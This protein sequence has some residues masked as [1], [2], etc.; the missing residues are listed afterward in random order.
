MNITPIS[1]NYYNPKFNGTLTFSKITLVKP[2]HVPKTSAIVNMD[3][4][5]DA[6][7][8]GKNIVIRLT[9]GFIYRYKPNE[10]DNIEDV[11]EKIGRA[12]GDLCHY[13][14]RKNFEKDYINKIF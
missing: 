3:L 4:F 2:E 9:N 7:I 11:L 1:Q 13:S 12:H 14:N 5:A 6:Y 8:V 10:N